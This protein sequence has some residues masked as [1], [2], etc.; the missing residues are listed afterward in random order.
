MSCKEIIMHLLSIHLLG[1]GLILQVKALLETSI[2]HAGV[3]GV[4]SPIPI[5]SV[6]LPVNLPEKAA[7][8]GSD[9]GSCHLQG[10]HRY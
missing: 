4:D 8:N 7:D 1:R 5:P 2:T 10:G 6:Q 9:I 3:L